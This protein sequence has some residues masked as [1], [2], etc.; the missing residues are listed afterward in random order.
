M[1]FRW[2]ALRGRYYVHLVQMHGPFPNSVR[3]GAPL[4][5]GL[6]HYLTFPACKVI[7]GNEAAKKQAA[8]C[9]KSA[10]TLAAHF[11]RIGKVPTTK[12]WIDSRPSD[13]HDNVLELEGK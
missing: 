10:P 4:F 5:A 13:P 1:P 11:A 2:A 8:D 6:S 7:A 12:A 3:V 9:L